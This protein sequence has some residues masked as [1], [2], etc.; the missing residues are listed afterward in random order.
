MDGGRL[1]PL[2]QPHG[3]RLLIFFFFHNTQAGMYKKDEIYI[4]LSK[5][6]MKAL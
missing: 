4:G 5:C 1:I 6:P 3:R 2:E